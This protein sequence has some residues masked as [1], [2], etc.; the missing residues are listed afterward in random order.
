MTDISNETD[1]PN[2]PPPRAAPYPTVEILQAAMAHRESIQSSFEAQRDTLI[3]AIAAQRQAVNQ[4]VA[5][6]R[7]NPAPQDIALPSKV[8]VVPEANSEAAVIQS[9]SH[10]P[11][12]DNTLDNSTSTEKMVAALRML[13]TPSEDAAKIAAAHHAVATQQ[14]LD[15]LK[16]AIAEEVSR[17]LKEKLAS[18]II[19][20]LEATISG[21]GSNTNAV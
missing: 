4:A 18:E 9:D 10:V 12:A 13:T 19:A 1:V 17:L 21:V 7:K 8:E 14:F 16:G 5:N 15:A 6:T 11:Q 3:K 20:V 2:E